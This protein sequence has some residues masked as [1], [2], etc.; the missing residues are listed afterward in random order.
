[1]LRKIPIAS[2]GAEQPLAAAI[3][4]TLARTARS[5]FA[6]TKPCFRKY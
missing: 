1:M 6:A 2:R 5:N 4:I 3:P